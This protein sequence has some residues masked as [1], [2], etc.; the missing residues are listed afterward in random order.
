[1]VALDQ[2]IGIWLV[3]AVA[4]YIVYRLF[5]SA[6]QPSLTSYEREMEE[7]LTS[8]KYKVKGQFEE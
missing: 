4:A 8:D 1:M 5:F 2:K 3:A 6:K 7:I